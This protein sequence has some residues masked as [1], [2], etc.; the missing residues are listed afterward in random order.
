MNLLY[1]QMKIT[2]SSFKYFVSKSAEMQLQSKKSCEAASI[3]FSIRKDTELCD[4]NV[5]T[6]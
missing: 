6:V 1:E 4:S 5:P 2:R 3:V